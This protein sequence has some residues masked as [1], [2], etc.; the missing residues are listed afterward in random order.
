MALAALTPN[1]LSVPTSATASF[2]LHP[3]YDRLTR[4]R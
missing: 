1:A 3:R 4:S 2:Q